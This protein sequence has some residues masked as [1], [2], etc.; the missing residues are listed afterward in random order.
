MTQEQVREYLE[1]IWQ[2]HQKKILSEIIRRNQPKRQGEESPDIGN[3]V[4][5]NERTN[6]MFNPGQ[7]VKCIN[8]RGA[9]PCLKRD[10]IYTVAHV[11]NAGELAD[12]KG[13]TGG[14]V[15]LQGHKHP[16]TGA[17]IRPPNFY[18]ASRFALVSD[19][20]P[21]NMNEAVRVSC[22]ETPETTD[23][24]LARRVSSLEDR[25]NE[26]ENND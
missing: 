12:H 13:R 23:G 2:E 14:G 16:R 7:K 25:V 21:T 15:M 26:L 10:F 8:D 3:D 9:R 18:A 17:D 11:F 19:A 5:Q 20:T 22:E 4:E 1:K 6:N 24:E